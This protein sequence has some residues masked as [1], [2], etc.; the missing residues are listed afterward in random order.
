MTHVRIGST[1]PEDTDTGSVRHYSSTRT[2]VSVYMEVFTSDRCCINK[3]KEE[4]KGNKNKDC[5]HII[6]V[7]VS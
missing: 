4:R 2:H 7:N 6:N 1:E 3:R 5:G